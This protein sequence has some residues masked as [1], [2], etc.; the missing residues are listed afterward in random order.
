[1]EK[2]Q[3]FTLIEL[4]IVIVILGILS[5]VALPRF[6]DFSTEAEN[7]AIM[8][9]AASISS[10]MSINYAACA[11]DQHDATSSR[12]IRVDPDTYQNACTLV[13]ANSVLSNTLELAEGYM[14][15]IDS[16]LSFPQNR[17]NGTTLGCSIIRPHKPPY[18]VVAQYNVIIAGKN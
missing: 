1:M 8:E 16:S 4:I 12:C 11:L 2:Q 7:A 15:G 18:G 10:A 9:S 17:P 3:G 5:A 13:T 14:I 6:M